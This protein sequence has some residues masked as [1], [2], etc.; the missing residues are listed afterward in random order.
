MAGAGQI[1]G[2][3]KLLPA[4]ALSMK[5]KQ[6]NYFEYSR[7]IPEQEFSEHIWVN[8]ELSESV[9]E[10]IPALSIELANVKPKAFSLKQ[11]QEAFCLALKFAGK[12]GC[13]VAGASACRGWLR[14]L[15]IAPDGGPQALKTVKYLLERSHKYLISS[16]STAVNGYLKYAALLPKKAQLQA[17]IN[18]ET[19]RELHG[20]GDTC[21]PR[22][23]NLHLGF[24]N[25]PA[26]AGF[27]PSALREGFALGASESS[28]DDEYPVGL[29]V[30]CVAELKNE[31]VDAVTGKL[32][33]LLEP[34]GGKLI[35][36]DCP[37]Q[38]KIKRK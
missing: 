37:G 19:L 10:N 36:W 5:I 8:L 2:G 4:R 26:A 28:R 29:V 27:M 18:G 1:A 3:T 13:I 17:V 24:P 34:F 15:I 7:S 6:S 31:S 20:L 22:R 21:A 11:L 30:H 33:D 16:E 38:A 14:L 25:E 35:F 23:L 32:I 12:A 9:F